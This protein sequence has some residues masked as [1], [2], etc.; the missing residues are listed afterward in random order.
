VL[1]VDL[2]VQARR[3]ARCRGSSSRIASLTTLHPS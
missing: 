2:R 3:P 1:R